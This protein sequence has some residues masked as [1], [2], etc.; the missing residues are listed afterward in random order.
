MAAAENLRFGIS[1]VRCLVFSVWLFSAYGIL[2][3]DHKFP[4]HSTL[5]SS[6]TTFAGLFWYVDLPPFNFSEHFLLPLHSLP[7]GLYLNL[8][9]LIHTQ[10]HY[11]T[12]TRSLAMQDNPAEPAQCQQQPKTRITCHQ[13]RLNPWALPAD[14]A[15][16]S[17]TQGARVTNMAI[18]AALS[19][20]YD[21][22][23]IFLPI[24]GSSNLFSEQCHGPNSLGEDCNTIR[25]QKGSSKSPSIS[26]LS[27][28]PSLYLGGPTTATTFV[29]AEERDLC[30]RVKRRSTSR[31]GTSQNPQTP[32]PNQHQS[33]KHKS[34]VLIV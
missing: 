28:T 33:Q 9:L 3:F 7:N 27:T 12:T 32:T 14:V 30:Y 1:G 19:Q 20:S 21:L 17:H 16:L 22:S 6:P 31:S 24:I 8:S 11:P 18:V 5:S 10:Q 4:Q 34:H 29:P 23:S 2:N 13:P 25:W 26:R 15:A